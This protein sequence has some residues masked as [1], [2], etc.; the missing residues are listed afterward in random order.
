[1]IDNVYWWDIET[2]NK[3]SINFWDLSGLPKLHKIEVNIWKE[4]YTWDF[5][6]YNISNK[7]YFQNSFT[8]RSY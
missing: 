3:L 2:N 8:K 7:E 5:E 1:M 4:Y 6:N